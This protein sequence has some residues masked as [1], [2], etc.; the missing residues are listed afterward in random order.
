MKNIVRIL[1]TAFLLTLTLAASLN[2]SLAQETEETEQFVFTEYYDEGQSQAQSSGT[3]GWDFVDYYEDTE[4]SDLDQM[5]IPHILPYP[6]PSFDG[7]LKVE[8][9]QLAK[10]S[11]LSVQDANGRLFHVARIGD[12]REPDGALPNSCFNADSGFVFAH[13]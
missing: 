10:S 8:Y 4:S 5:G 12:S 11:E 6:N 2:F 7:I 1:T 13:A 3:N 9:K